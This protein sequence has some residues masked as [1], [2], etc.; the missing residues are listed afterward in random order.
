MAMRVFF[1]LLLCLCYFGCSTPPMQGVAPVPTCNIAYDETLKPDEFRGVH[2]SP[3][4]MLAIQGKVDPDYEVRSAK[5]AADLFSR[6]HEPPLPKL[7][8]C[9]TAA[10]RITWVPSFHR[11]SIVRVWRSEDGQ[12]ITIKRLERTANNRNGYSYSEKTR[13]ISIGD[14]KA[15][16]SVVEKI[17]FWSQ[18]STELEPLPNDGAGWLIEGRC[19]DCYHSVFRI[20]PE[21]GLEMFIRGIFAMTGEKTEIDEYLPDDGVFLHE[22]FQ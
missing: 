16:Q 4:Y 22:S 6:F 8:N 20:N 7:P 5:D 10:Y 14:W 21:P 12:F 15:V 1:I 13:R 19:L 18:P 3:D 11:T 2:L 17:Q 9:V